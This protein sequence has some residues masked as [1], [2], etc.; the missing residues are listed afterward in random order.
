M[1]IYSNRLKLKYE[2]KKEDKGEQ[3]L[4]RDDLRSAWWFWSN[5]LK[6][7]NRKKTNKLRS[8]SRS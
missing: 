8:F 5:A 3:T 6:R 1:A 7:H 4:Y 2:Q